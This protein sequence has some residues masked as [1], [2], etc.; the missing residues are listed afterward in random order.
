MMDITELIK[1]IDQQRKELDAIYHG[2]AVK[3]G[4]SDTALWVLYLVSE[5]GSDLTQQDLC[6]QNC[7]PK[8]TVNTAVNSL[9]KHGFL[10]LI[11]IQGTRNHKKVRLT[12]TGRDLANRTTQKLKI[13]EEN[14][15]KR[16]TPA[17]LQVHL[18]ITSRLTA[19]IREETEKL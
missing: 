17:K 19:Y 4:L 11:P 18:D 14:A 8:Q 13:A 3:Y 6:R 15:Y 12:A 2:V 5:D 10:E 1:Q 7:F 16:F 9:A